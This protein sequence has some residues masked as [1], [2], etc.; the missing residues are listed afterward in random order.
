[1]DANMRIIETGD[2]VQL[3]SGGPRMTAAEVSTDIVICHWFD[4]DEH[5]H[6]QGFR[7][8]MLA[9]VIDEPTYQTAT[10]YR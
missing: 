7:P 2:I 8:A 4:H 5:A 10:I 9:A 6:L 1:M 3:K